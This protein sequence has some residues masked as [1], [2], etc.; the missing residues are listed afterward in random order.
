MI[1]QENLTWRLTLTRAKSV[2]VK[3]TLPSSSIG[4]F[5][6]TRRLYDSRSGHL[7]GKVLSIEST[8][9]INRFTIYTLRGPPDMM[10]TSKRGGGHGKVDVL[11]EVAYKSV[12]NVDKGG[13]GQKILWTALMKDT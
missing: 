12:P 13:G 8:E 3:L 4:M 7:E 2:V 5:M 10:S 11:R 6:R 1:Y 9:S